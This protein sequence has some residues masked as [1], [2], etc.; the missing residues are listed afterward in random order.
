MSVTKVDRGTALIRLAD[1]HITPVSNLTGFVL[2]A[3]A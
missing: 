1:P 2:S 3:F